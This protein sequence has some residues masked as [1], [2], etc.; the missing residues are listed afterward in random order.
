MLIGRRQQ[1]TLEGPRLTGSRDCKSYTLAVISRRPRKAQG[2]PGPKI[3]NLMLAVVSRRPQKALGRSCES[4]SSG[5]LLFMHQMLERAPDHNIVVIFR[6]SGA[7][8]GPGAQ[9][10]CNLCNSV[11]FFE[12]LPLSMVKAC[13]SYDTVAFLEF[14]HLETCPEH[15]TVAT[16]LCIVKTR[17]SYDTAK[18]F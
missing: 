10:C 16:Q 8:K 7:Q 18:I 1:E 4:R 2:R 13:R 15:E 5:T 12:L 17:R 14:W 6:N 3:A 9:Y 11:E